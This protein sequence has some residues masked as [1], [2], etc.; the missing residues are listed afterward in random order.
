MRI[1]PVLILNKLQIVLTL[2]VFAL[3]FGA[4]NGVIYHLFYNIFYLLR[5]KRGSQST[6]ALAILLS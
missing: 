2:R 4:V 1:S 3:Y 5:W 6:L